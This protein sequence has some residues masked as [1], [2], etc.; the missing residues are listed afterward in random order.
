MEGFCLLQ[1]VRKRFQLLTSSRKAV[2]P[3]RKKNIK[4]TESVQI[5]LSDWSAVV[6][7]LIGHIEN[8]SCRWNNY[9]VGRWKSDGFKKRSLLQ[10]VFL[11]DNELSNQVIGRWGNCQDGVPSFCMI[12]FF[13]ASSLLLN[14]GRIYYI[15]S[16]S[17]F[18]IALWSCLFFILFR[19]QMICTLRDELSRSCREIMKLETDPSSTQQVKIVKYSWHSDWIFHRHRRILQCWCTI[20]CNPCVRAECLFFQKILP[21]PCAIY[22]SIVCRN[23]FWGDEPTSF[24]SLP[25]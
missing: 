2:F 15:R 18:I 13:L 7:C 4:P 19:S 23:W 21:L 9:Q 11:H 5:L 8:L 3:R 22:K 17:K 10:L 1:D 24:L 20:P 6:D 14:I 16:C 25:L 12:W